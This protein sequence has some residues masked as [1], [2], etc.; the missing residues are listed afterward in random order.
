M[1]TEE[2]IAML[3]RGH[4]EVEPRAL[5]R[6]VVLGLGLGSV[7]SGA[8]L[9]A[10]L[11]IRVD[12]FAALRLPMFWVKLGFATSL[13]LASLTL[14]LRL[15]R[16][17]R[18]VGHSPRA[19]LAPVAALWLL[20]IVS[21]MAAAPGQRLLL[22]FGHTWL[23]CPWLIAMLALPVFGGSMWALAGLAPTHLRMAGASAG[24]LS[25]A[26]ATLLYSLHCPEMDA[27]FLA[28]WYLLG[29]ILPTLL[30]ALLGPRLLRW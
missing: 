12:L 23:V 3:A 22:V 15:A 25:G 28:V 2:F 4:V 29:I 30:G 20:A 17:G 14:L 7:A 13:M 21:L 27:P 6:R 9:A 11:D 18:S 8:L 26:T 1:K 24:L 10:T 5:Q 16:P 19:I